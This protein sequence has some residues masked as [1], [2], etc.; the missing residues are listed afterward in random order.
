VFDQA[1]DAAS[2][3]DMNDRIFDRLQQDRDGR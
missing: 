2:T 3:R 1:V